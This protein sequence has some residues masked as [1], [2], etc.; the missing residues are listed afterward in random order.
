MTS[1][2]KEFQSNVPE[3]I[4]YPQEATR[5]RPFVRTSASTS[6]IMGMVFAA[7]ILVGAGGVYYYGP[8][9]LILCLISVISA[10]LSEMVYS[11]IAGRGFTVKDYSAAVTG[12]MLGLILPPS[13]PYYFAVIGAA[14]GIILGKCVFGGIGRNWL[15]PAMTGKLL[16]I[17]LF[18]NAMGNY[19]VGEYSA[20]S[21]LTQFTMG[22]MVNTRDLLTGNVSACI[23]TGCTP[24]ILV[25]VVFLLLN[26]I[27][28][29][30]IPVAGLLSFT[31]LLIL[32]G[33]HG[34]DAGYLMTQICGGGFLFT[35][36]LMATDF[37][38]SP[39]THRGKVWYGILFGC[40]T[41]LLRL[42]CGK[43]ENAVVIALLLVNL[44]ARF[45]DRHTMPQP[46]GMLTR[47]GIPRYG[48]SGNSSPGRSF[49]LKAGEKERN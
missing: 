29:P 31:G 35:L 23:G 1:I 34:W 20:I 44:T 3:R 15:N 19:S 14:G 9:A 2:Q 7:L 16:L 17:L 38:T 11:A 37:T 12:L 10:V 26:G 24:M 27:I 30:S 8:H 40:L 46:F 45:L 49:T 41:A 42:F 33:H 5:I 4:V 43:T 28:D 21:P 22:N 36:S 32:F 48:I 18:R 25:A 39:V 13:V 6:S 47:Y